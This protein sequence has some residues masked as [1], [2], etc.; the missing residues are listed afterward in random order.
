MEPEPTK[1]IM[2]DEMVKKGNV[3]PQFVVTFKK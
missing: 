3:F 1:V 2:K